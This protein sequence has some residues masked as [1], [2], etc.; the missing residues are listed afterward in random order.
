M[1]EVIKEIQDK[2]DENDLYVE[3]PSKGFPYG[4]ETEPHVTLAVLR[5]NVKLD[6]IKPL[7]CPLE[8][9][10]I[11]L[12]NLSVFDD[13]DNDERFDVLKCDVKCEALDSTNVKISE[14]YSI[15]KRHKKFNGHLTVAFL[16]KSK[17][18]EYEQKLAGQLPKTVTLEPVHFMF[19]KED[20]LEIFTE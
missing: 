19:R 12:I 15:N 13:N 14:K 17:G 4:K 10:K 3:D 16:K 7:L 11:E 5:G 2:I 8:N 6:N 1:T 20:S 9:Y 18:K